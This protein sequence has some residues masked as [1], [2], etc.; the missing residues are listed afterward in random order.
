MRVYMKLLFA[1]L[2]TLLLVPVLHSFSAPEPGPEVLYSECFSM[3]QKAQARGD[4]KKSLDLYHKSLSFAQ[5]MQSTDKQL[6]SLEKIAL[7][8]WNQ[9]KYEESTQ[10]YHT[11][12][13]L[14]EKLGDIK[15]QNRLETILLI[16]QLYS[17]GRAQADSGDRQKSIQTLQQAVSL[18]K[19]NEF[20]EHELK[21]L[22]YLSLSHYDMDHILEFKQLNEQALDIA[23]KLN[24]NN[25]I[26]KCA[27]NIGIFHLKYKNY[28]QALFYFEEALHIAEEF[29]NKVEIANCSNNIGIIYKYIGNYDKALDY[30]NQALTI[31]R[32]LG[33]DLYISIDLNVIGTV[34]RDMGLFH[35]KKSYFENALEKFQECLI[36]SRK[37]KR[38]KSEIYVLNNIGN[39]YS[40][41][42]EYF[43]KE[44][45]F[46]QAQQTFE[47]AL[48]KAEAEND[49]K[50]KGMILNNLGIIH[51]NQGNYHESTQ[52]F[53]KAIDLGLKIEGGKFLW[54][55]YLELAQVYMKQNKIKQAKKYFN[56][57]ISIIE[58][59][60]SSI[61]L[62]ELKASFLGTNKR[63]EA[64]HG[65][66]HILF[67]LSKKEPHQNHAREAFDYLERAK[68]RA[69]LDR[70]ELSQVNISQFIDFKL[71][72]QEK[73]LMK[74]ISGI[75]QKLLDS[76]LTSQDSV[77]LHKELKR[78]EDDLETLK[79]KIRNTHPAYA[80][81]RY[82]E[83]ISLEEAQ[84]MLDPQTAFFEYLISEKNSYLFVITKNN[85]HIHSLPQKDHIQSLVTDYLEKISD[86]ENHDFSE[87]HTLYKHLVKPGLA[88][89]IKKII[90]VPDDI[91]NFLPFEALVSQPDSNKWLVHDFYVS[92]S[93]SI[94]S[95]N[96]I[97]NRKKTNG[98]KRHKDLLAV[99]DP[100]FKP[101]RNGNNGRQILGTFDFQRLK[102]SG[103]EIDQISSLFKPSQKTIYKRNKATEEALKRTNLENYKIIHLATHSLID[104]QQPF[105]SSIVLALD[106]N[107]QEDGFLQTREIYNISLNADL[108]VLSACETGLGQFIKGEGIEGINRSFFYAGTSAVLMSL[109]PVNDQATFQMM[110][111]FYTHLRS[112]ESIINSLRDTKLELINSKALSH[113]YYWAG[114]VVSGK[115]D[116]KIFSS[117][118]LNTV[119]I[120][121]LLLMMFVF[122]FV[123]WSR[124]RKKR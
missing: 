15:N 32:E 13:T 28:S 8:L 46:Q 5:T 26:G 59:I 31:D 49:I 113:P 29:N 72:N 18:C 119:M 68:A 55:A 95:L 70:L 4:F 104:N 90:F 34:Y 17:E 88:P 33:G 114:F 47:E 64:Y 76:E 41:L 44:E 87:G 58:D 112:S 85:L 109:W 75:Y 101:I 66:I 81:L 62:E 37:I 118:S 16:H 123:F 53:Q 63:I 42:H 100:Y 9:G 77:N 106:E 14:A 74:D 83:I 107:P 25:E 52:Y 20:K 40:D 60:R 51:S 98:I 124:H 94:S 39:V 84:N 56:L 69:F 27:N 50:S 92:Y 73:E 61:K 121:I 12:L 78:K 91:L 30:L 43:G 3:A 45:H 24:H 105:R 122:L 1:F 120:G 11:A 19:E 116:Q 89:N 103:T 102:Y 80:N 111:R 57:S 96:E 108:V 99:G 110:E 67:S 115:T 97:I 22:R 93:P 38:M 6:Q 86:N 10:K 36:L 117:L 82:P 79:R 2:V 71:Q 48:N 35:K 21:C 7:V 54:E 23:R 65:L